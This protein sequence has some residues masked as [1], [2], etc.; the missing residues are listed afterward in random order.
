VVV[1]GDFSANFR[2]MRL[3]IDHDPETTCDAG[4]PCIFTLASLQKTLQQTKK[5]FCFYVCE[6][7]PIVVCIDVSCGLYSLIHCNCVSYKD[8]I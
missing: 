8:R 4:I 2:D 5:L 3:D 1:G 6:S 7:L